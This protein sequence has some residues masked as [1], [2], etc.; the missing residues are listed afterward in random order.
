MK[1]LC[2]FSSYDNDSIIY[3]YV[4]HLVDELNRQL[5]VDRFIFVTTSKSM[6]DVQREK[7]IN[8]GVEPHLRE[9]VGYDFGSYFYGINL[10]SD[11]LYDYDRVFFINDSVYG[12]FNDVK[13]L[14]SGFD[15]LDLWGLTDSWQY[16]YHI[17]SYFLCINRSGY[18]VLRKFIDNYKYPD[19]YADVVHSGEIGFT[20]AFLK[21]NSNVCS[22]FPLEGL[23]AENLDRSLK[24]DKLESLNRYAI[25][26]QKYNQYI[27]SRML[28]INPCLDY[29][30]TLIEKGFPFIKKKHVI[31]QGF[32][33]R[34]MGLWYVSIDKKYEKAKSLMYSHTVLVRNKDWV[35]ETKH[36]ESKWLLRL[37]TKRKAREKISH[38]ARQTRKWF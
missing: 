16:N 9:N 24:K 38:L 34:H 14:S 22:A 37:R 15:E 12:P 33:L 35:Y 28:N 13:A 6:D 30:K 7:L 21:S 1:T 8:I 18:E 32:F 36:K 17:Q 25:D 26:M 29:W 4:Y 27:Y 11:K 20:Q 23:I 31:K 19:Q 5:D 10:V 2:I 3:P